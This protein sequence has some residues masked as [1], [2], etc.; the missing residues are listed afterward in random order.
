MPPA[1]AAHQRPHPGGRAGDVRVPQPHRRDD[2]GRAR[3]AEQPDVPP[4]VAGGGAVDEQVVDDLALAVE[5]G[6][7]GRRPRADGREAGAAVV[8]DVARVPGA[9]PV[10]GAVAV[11][12]E[13]QVVRQLVAGAAGVGTAHVR[14]VVGER[15][16]VPGRVA[17][18][19]R[20]VAVQIPAD[21]VQLRQVAYVDQP[22]VVAVVV[23]V[24]QAELQR[25]VEAAVLQHRMLVGA[26]EVPGV[27]VRI[28]GH[29]RHAVAVHVL[30]VPSGVEARVVRRRLQLAGGLAFRGVPVVVVGDAAQGG[31]PI[32]RD[33][34]LVI[35]ACHQ[36]IVGGPARHRACRV[37][38]RDGLREARAHQPATRAVSGDRHC[39]PRVAR[40]DHRH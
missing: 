25:R 23:A 5:G 31:V 19:G 11:R 8:V 30:V 28:R 9:V 37:G 7:E 39:R 21:G 16:A 3:A 17:G 27:V 29:A 12:V 40:H 22:V 24:L 6:V 38:R 13:V 33:H 26:A 34:I 4:G 15:L 2:G 10:R 1:V 32:A 18:G 14:G 36:P 20:T 35:G